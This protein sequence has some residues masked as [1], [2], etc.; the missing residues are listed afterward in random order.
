MET[1][2]PREEKTVSGVRPRMSAS[3]SLT[4]SASGGNLAAGANKEK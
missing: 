1:S 2:V 3:L 4:F